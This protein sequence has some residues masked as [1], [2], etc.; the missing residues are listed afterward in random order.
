MAERI[1]MRIRAFVII[2][3]IP[4]PTSS[5][6]ASFNG[7]TSSSPGTASVGS[8]A[9]RQPPPGYDPQ[10]ARQLNSSAPFQP[11]PGYYTELARQLDVLTSG[12]RQIYGVDPS[13]SSN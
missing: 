5:T 3:I 9:F 12:Y 6:P 1:R 2:D 8:P 10:L 7:G 11:R 4:N 13:E